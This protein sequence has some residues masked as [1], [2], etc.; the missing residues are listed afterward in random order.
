MPKKRPDPRG[1]TKKK[2]EEMLR[3]LG[4]KSGYK[5]PDALKIK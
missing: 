1:V 5:I 2:S 3:K 4:K